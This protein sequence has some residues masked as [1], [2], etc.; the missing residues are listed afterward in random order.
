VD[1]LDAGKQDLRLDVA[2]VQPGAVDPGRRLRPQAQELGEVLADQLP[3]VGQ[4]DDP[5]VGPLRQHL[6]DE[7]GH[8]Q[9]LAAGG[10]DNHQRMAARRHEV[11][12][13]RVD[14]GALIGAQLQDHAAPSCQ[15]LPSGLR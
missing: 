6:L 14:G 5:F 2:A 3:D 13:D 7:G 10:R 1:R 12:V 11:G 9:R 4:D 15:T 8:D